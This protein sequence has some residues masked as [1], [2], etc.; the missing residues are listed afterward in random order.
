MTTTSGNGADHD[1]HGFSFPGRF[2]I[3]AMGDAEAGLRQR[4]PTLL[5]REGVN[6]LHESVRHRHS[7]KGNYIS[8]TVEFDCPTREHYE[9]AHA[10]LRADPDIKYTL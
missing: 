10:V 5:E 9:A 4:V 7:A 6:V 8:V 2:R 1:K 3:T